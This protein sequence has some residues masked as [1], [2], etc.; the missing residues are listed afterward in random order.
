M[1][2]NQT[3]DENTTQS[4]QKDAE[5][6][7]QYIYIYI[8]FLHGC[9]VATHNSDERES[10]MENDNIDNQY[11]IYKTFLEDDKYWSLKMDGW[12]E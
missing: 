1:R 10:M 2:I 9:V 12:D 7:Y 4:L 5:G 3:I 8:F 11:M 6:S